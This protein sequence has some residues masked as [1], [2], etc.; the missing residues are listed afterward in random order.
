MSHTIFLIQSNLS[1]LDRIKLQ[2]YSC[3]T[4]STENI[5]DPFHYAGLSGMML[6]ASQSQTIYSF[7]ELRGS[8]LHNSLCWN[9]RHFR[10][11][12]LLRSRNHINNFKSNSN[13]GQMS[14]V[15]FSRYRWFDSPPNYL[16]QYSPSQTM[17]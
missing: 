4:T 10:L 7:G 2:T 16:D 13:A 12:L 8:A 6:A 5:S 9:R 3:I 17:A 1:K 11:C 14:T 15:F